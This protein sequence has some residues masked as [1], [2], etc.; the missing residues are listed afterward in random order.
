MENILIPIY[1]LCKLLTFRAFTSVSAKFYSILQE[2]NL[3]FL[4][5]TP[6]FTKHPHQF[7]YS[8]HLF[9][10]IF[11]SLTLFIYS[12]NPLISAPAWALSPTNQP[13]QSTILP[14]INPNRKSISHHCSS[15]FANT[16]I[17]ECQ[18]NFQNLTWQ[19]PYHHQPKRP[20]HHPLCL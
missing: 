20:H 3:L 6:T 15:T 16:T 5:Y 14:P 12:R 9:N 4:F 8:T 1:N 2:K 7:I 13:H 10:K 18:W 17:N 11:I 19:P